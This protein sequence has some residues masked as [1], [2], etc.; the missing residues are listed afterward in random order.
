[1]TEKMETTLELSEISEIQWIK[2]EN[3]QLDDI[4]FDSQKKFLADYFNL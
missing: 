2:K 1:M 3:I 4:A